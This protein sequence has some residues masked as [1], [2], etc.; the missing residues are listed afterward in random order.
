MNKPFTAGR[1]TWHGGVNRGVTKFHLVT[2]SGYRLN[3][4]D[5]GGEVDMDRARQL[6]E[7]AIIRKK[8]YWESNAPHIIGDE[9]LIIVKE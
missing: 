7:L 6:A 3:T 1:E 5:F 4:I 2:S 9:R 8:V